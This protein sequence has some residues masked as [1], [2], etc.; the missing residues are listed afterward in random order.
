[1]SEKG[2]RHY[3]L[4]H[5][6]L[7]VYYYRNKGDGPPRAIGPHASRPETGFLR[8]FHLPAEM[9]KET[10][11]LKHHP[12]ALRSREGKKPGFCA[13]FSLRRQDISKKPGFKGPHAIAPR[14]RA[15][16]KP[17][18]VPIFSS[19]RREISKKPGFSTPTL[20][21]KSLSSTYILTCEVLRSLKCIS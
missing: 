13:R 16:Q 21:E 8:A 2:D 17:G 3:D 9:V 20:R 14:S 11:F 5:V 7:H 15:D 10:R 4:N 19:P 12:I 1:M 18:L 6:S